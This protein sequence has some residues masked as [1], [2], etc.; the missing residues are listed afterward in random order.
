MSRHEKIKG[1]KMPGL[2]QKRSFAAAVLF[3]IL[4]I[5]VFSLAA[6]I[7]SVAVLDGDNVTK[8]QTL[9]RDPRDILSQAGVV[10]DNEDDFTVTAETGRL[11]SINIS[12]AFDVYIK[13][14]GETFAVKMLSGTVKD[15]I[16][17][18][19]VYMDDEDVLSVPEDS[20]VTANLTFEVT[21]VNYSYVRQEHTVPYG[22]ATEYSG[23]LEKGVS[24]TLTAGVEGLKVVTVRLKTRDGQVVEETPVKE[25][26]VRHPVEEKTVVGTKAAAKTAAAAPLSSK[27]AVSGAPEKVI[28]AFANAYSKLQ[29]VSALE[30]TENAVP[31]KYKQLITGK[32]TAYHQDPA[33]HSTAT[34]RPLMVGH[35]A[36]NPRQ[37]PYGSKLWIRTANGQII[38]GYAIAADTGGFAGK[39]RITIDLFFNT[40]AECYAF[41][42]RDV[43]IYVLE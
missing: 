43:E 28:T 6:N 3:T 24:K 16:D 1:F 30:F 13:A 17:K 35:V 32:A 7:K 21:R 27:A 11:L 33:T 12:R 9:S 29:P 34:G 42:V 15:A 18:S 41:G 4:A 8:V 14:D 23:T 22:T 39:G 37:I 19:G 38:Y 5:A 2:F 10:L 25:E 31:L 40:D 26:I 20:P 36:V